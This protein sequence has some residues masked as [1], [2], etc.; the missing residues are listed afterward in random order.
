MINMFLGPFGLQNTGVLCY[1]N[2]LLQS[3]VSCPSFNK[4]ILDHKEYF[5]EN[6]KRLCIEYIKLLESAGISVSNTSLDNSFNIGYYNGSA[7]LS[8]MVKA[9]RGRKDTLLHGRQEDFHEGLTFLIE[10]IGGRI[11]DLFSIRYKMEIKCRNPDCKTPVRS[12]PK[13]DPNFMFHL[14]EED[15]VLQ[16]SLTTKVSNEELH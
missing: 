10:Q 7:I 16:D 11:K 9:R 4:I 1:L 14:F 13:E 3:L 12:G 5:E 6:D 15:P 2:T 8:E